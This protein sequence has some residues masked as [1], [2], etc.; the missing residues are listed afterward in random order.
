MTSPAQKRSWHGLLHLTEHRAPRW[1]LAAIGLPLLV[2][3]V[4]LTTRPLSSLSVIALLIG[5]SAIVTGVAEL[6]TAHRRPA[7]LRFAAGIGWL[8]G[9]VLAI[10]WLG[11]SIELLPVA[12]CVL[13]VAGS[14][15]SLGGVARGQLGERVLAGA[16]TAAQLSFA[17]LALIWPDATLLVVAAL[18]GVRVA[19]HGLTL[20]WRAARGVPRAPRRLRAAL[21][22]IGAVLVVALAGTAVWGSTQLRRGL[23]V[24]DDFYSAPGTVPDDPGALLRDEAWGGVEP[25]GAE[26]RRI[27]YTT[28]DVHDD[29]RLGSAL[30]IS[31]ADAPDGPRPVILWDH[32]TTG[33]ARTCA[34]SLLEDAF[35][36]HT[37]P[38]LQEVL[39]AGWVVVA[40]DYSG[41]GTDG[42][43][44]YLVGQGEAR[45]GLDAARAAASMEGLDLSPDTVVWGH[46]QGGHAAL[47]TG[48]VGPAYAPELDLLGVAA[49]SPAADPLALAERI[50]QRPSSPLPAI[51]VAWVLVPYAE[52]YPEIDLDDYVDPAG[53]VLVREISQR[54]VADPRLA[55]SALDGLGVARDRP[56][57]VG[58][59]T[60]GVTAQRLDE[61]VARGPW[62]MPLLVAWGDRDEVIAPELQHDYVAQLCAAGADFSWSEVAGDDHLAIVQDSTFLD[63]LLRWTE[64][65]FAG[66]DAPAPVC[67]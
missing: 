64:D 23:P 41:Q 4:L 3:G 66:A 6:V 58:D 19:L 33:I 57:F 40:T 47:W 48:A 45:S 22:W 1:L 18:F 36:R 24:V 26:V 32:G 63:P 25:D 65:R 10:V 12:V 28:T 53:R 61:N 37:I 49:L 9:G 38:A 67:G 16:L 51:V 54:C 30:V 39:A 34:P 35:E 50:L 60:T 8:L 11:R 59:L 17:V 31:P 52:T 27:L 55:V 62:E 43:F 7:A 46:S 5:A 56:L 20:L 2:G 15:A 42:P 21:P 29:A 44:P 13:L 14:V